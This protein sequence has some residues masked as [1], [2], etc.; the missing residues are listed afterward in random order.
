MLAFAVHMKCITY[1]LQFGAEINQKVTVPPVSINCC[2]IR[3]TIQANCT[4]KSR[5]KRVYSTITLTSKV[6]TEIIKVKI[7]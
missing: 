5:H 2:T 6:R 3:E 7:V 1:H 4:L